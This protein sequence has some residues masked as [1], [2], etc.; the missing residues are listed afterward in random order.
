MI[1]TIVGGAVGGLLAKKLKIPGGMLVGAII[2]VSMIQVLT[3]Q[4]VMPEKSK[5]V[6]QFITGAYIG[7]MI[8]K[9]D[10]K[11]LPSVIKPF[12][13]VIISFFCLNMI[14]GFIIWNITD[15]DFYTA[16]LCA[17][18]GGISDTPL[19]AMD[20]GADV[21]K[22]TAMQ[23]TRLIFGL[24]ALPSVIV[25]ID[26]FFPQQK[27]VR[28]DSAS[29]PATDQQVHTKSHSKKE[30]LYLL[31]TLGIAAIGSMVGAAL[32]VPAGALLFSMLFVLFSK[33]TFFPLAQLPMW[34]RRAAQ[35][36]SGC[37]IGT[38]MYYEDLIQLRQIII[39]V[40]VLLTAYLINCILTGLL[41]SKYF[42]MDRKE[43]MLCVSPAGAT[44]MAMIAG[45][46]GVDSPQLILIQICRLISV[47]SIFPQVIAILANFI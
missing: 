5:L 22:V 38:R 21:A 42:K 46:L 3:G 18:P 32:D 34:C 10:L 8:K 13:V 27:S 40:V 6:A 9:S 37:V 30:L 41:L 7:C 33:M 23:F 44:E 1:E 47:L 31:V 14:V 2:A 20:M 43:G 25:M 35:I 15:F 4:A 24:V 16:M 36:L 45:D 29:S 17:L 39:P 28:D 12:S 11:R 19:I 26:H